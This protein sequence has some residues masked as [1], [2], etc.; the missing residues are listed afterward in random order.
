M[1]LKDGK[2]P[3][4]AFTWKMVSKAIPLH[5]L[6]LH[7][8]SLTMLRLE[9]PT[10]S[11][12]YLSEEQRDTGPLSF[13]Y[14]WMNA[15]CV[16]WITRSNVKIAG[17][18][19]WPTHSHL[20]TC[21][22][23]VPHP[24]H[25]ILQLHCFETGFSVLPTNLITLNWTCHKVDSRLKCW[26]M[27]SANLLKSFY[28]ILQDIRRELNIEPFVKLD[29]LI[30]EESEAQNAKVDCSLVSN[31]RHN[32]LGISCDSFLNSHIY[33]QREDVIDAKKTLGS[34]I[35]PDK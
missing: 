4:C 7:L 14:C 35:T 17:W 23:E 9:P 28:L 31:I 16:D 24:C 5:V 26:P 21:W 25:F 10:F 2:T 3:N 1:I 18:L 29:G 32:I 22:F 15:T 34:I 6:N 12:T 19:C 8:H 30:T 11:I 13:G 33:R 20:N 27:E